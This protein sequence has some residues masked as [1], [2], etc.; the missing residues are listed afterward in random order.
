MIEPQAGEIYRHYKRG[1]EYKIVCIAVVEATGEKS[2]V[3]EALYP[4][5]EERFWIR[6]LEEFCMDVAW[7]GKLVARFERV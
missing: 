2:V 7:E 1:G 5:A 4:D 3:Y 6:R